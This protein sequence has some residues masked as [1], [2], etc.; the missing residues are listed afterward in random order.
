[1]DKF[2]RSNIELLKSGVSNHYE[3]TTENVNKNATETYNLLKK[4]SENFKPILDKISVIGDMFTDLR[5]LNGTAKNVHY[6]SDL[7]VVEVEGIEDTSQGFGLKP[8][9]KNLKEISVKDSGISSIE[10]YRLLDSNLKS[11][12]VDSFLKANEEVQVKFVN[13]KYS[14]SLNLMY[15]KIEQINSIE[16]QLGLT[17]E[18]YPI[19]SSIKYVDSYNNFQDVIIN[20]NS[21]N[22]DLDETR[23]KDNLYILGITPIKT[24]QLIIEFTSRESSSIIFKSIKTYFT[25]MAKNGHLILGP[26]HTEKPILKLA[27]DA[28]ESTSGVSYAISTDKEFWIPLTL[29][30]HMSLDGSKIISFNTI[31][32]LSLKTNT[33][34]YSIYIK[35]EINSSILEDINNNS[36]SLYREDGV[37]SDNRMTQIDDNR[38]SAYRVKNSDF[39]YGKYSY[40]ENLNVS[41]LSLSMVEVLESNG[42]FKVLGLQDTRYSI[43]QKSNPN[44]VIGSFGVELK[45]KRQPASSIIDAKD[46]DIANAKLFDIYTRY[47]EETINVKQR[48][49]LIFTLKQKE[50]M[51]KIVGKTTRKSV[52]IDLTTPFTSN[53]I[54]TIIQVPYEDII[55]YDSLNNE[56]STILKKDL[57]LIEE[58]NN[59]LEESTY[60]INLVDLLFEPP[61]IE[62]LKLNKLF[63]IEALKDGEY[64]LSNGYI[65]VNSNTVLKYKGYELIKTEVPVVKTVNYTNNNFI[66]RVEDGF[67]YYEE[68][69]EDYYELKNVI[70]LKNASIEKGS[71]L[72]EEFYGDIN[73]Y[74]SEPLHLQRLIN[75]STKE[76]PTY[77]KVDEDD[78]LLKE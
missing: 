16:L 39:I 7:E 24:K 20:N 78:N 2:E 74:I 45:L 43:T 69:Y 4:V 47:F 73:D 71:I 58:I 49:N 44:A 25:K 57:L 35:I 54:N 37:I 5:L 33:D 61:I 18:S 60:F 46:F 36:L 75:V 64:G 72:I 76:D 13:N 41:S 29:S 8:T 70:K 23:V 40:V 32:D 11:T 17:T 6:L 22:I 48:G 67:T 51:Y 21:R 63:P 42:T 59:G 9:L 53:S 34:V 55:I 50:G 27:I 66:K 38:L 62:D 1:M 26:I 56:I 3:T 12:T 52:D 30:S 19:V 14:F 77:V 15:P 65:E 31:N 68:Q 28:T 10:S